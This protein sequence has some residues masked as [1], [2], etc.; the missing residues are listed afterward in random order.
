LLRK[1][2]GEPGAEVI[3]QGF[4]NMALLLAHQRRQQ[5]RK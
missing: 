4:S 1:G 2:D 3:A 5:N